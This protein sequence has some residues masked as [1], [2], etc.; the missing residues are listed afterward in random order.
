MKLYCPCCETKNDIAGISR[1]E[2]FTCCNCR[3]KF[4]GTKADIDLVG[5]L[6]S[7]F[8]VPLSW[9]SGGAINRTHCPSCYGPIEIEKLGPKNWSGPTTCPW[10]NENL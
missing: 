3:Q 2:T 1:F 7:K 6:C 10:C 8:F 5:H 9:Q 4:K